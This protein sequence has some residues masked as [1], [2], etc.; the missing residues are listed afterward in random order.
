MRQWVAQKKVNQANTL[1]V[2]QSRQ[3][4]TPGAGGLQ[5]GGD[6]TADR[7]LSLT[8][9][10]TP[11]TYGDSTHIPQITTDTKGRITNVVN[12]SPAA[13]G[14][15]GLF[16]MT[17]GVPAS[18]GFSW[19][20]QGTATITEVAG[21]AL[22][23]AN[24]GTSGLALRVKAVPG[25][26]YRLVVLMQHTGLHVFGGFNDSVSYCGW[27]DGTNK[28]SGI[29]LLNR[30]NSN[31]AQITQDNYTNPT[32]YTS[33]SASF[34]HSP[35][36]DVLFGL[37]DDGTN[38]TFSYSMDGVNFVT[39]FSVAKASGFLGSSGYTNF[40]F[41]H[42]SLSGSITTYS[43]LRLYDTNGLSRSYP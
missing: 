7:T 4:I 30:N 6:L 29:G 18:S 19:V 28:F 11:G 25:T 42:V 3:L 39:V 26:P 36:G 37:A 13:G 17:A 1:F 33:T 14:G 8:N 9:V 32:T 34:N 43:T 41:G 20:N 31:G 27:Y 2:P 15:G 23:I 38:V 5:G 16:D 35:N 24:S 12:V 40:A 22:T 21:K 10:G